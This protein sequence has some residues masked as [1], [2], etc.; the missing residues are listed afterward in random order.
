M[1]TLLD[2]V[3]DLAHSRICPNF[4]GFYTKKKKKYQNRRLLW[5]VLPL[6]CQHCSGLGTQCLL[7]SQ[8]CD[9]AEP[10]PVRKCIFLDAL[11]W[12]PLYTDLVRLNLCSTWP[13]PRIPW[14]KACVLSADRQ[15]EL[16]R[17][18]KILSTGP[19]EVTSKSSVAPG[20]I[21]QLNSYLPLP[22][23]SRMLTSY[24]C[25]EGYLWNYLLVSPRRTFCTFLL[26]YCIFVNH[27]P[28]TNLGRNIYQRNIL[29]APRKA[30]PVFSHRH[31][32]AGQGPGRELVCGCLLQE[33]I[34]DV[35]S[36]RRRISISDKRFSFSF[37]FIHLYSHIFNL[38]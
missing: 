6:P 8:Y 21:K 13:W 19:Q 32:V 38:K 26:E 37:S 11:V 17:A 29:S 33:W 1:K 12:I 27:G 34:P 36:F 5:N 28:K 25:Q 14:G 2:S 20:W 16:S 24:M 4:A 23:T 35:C 15:C 10:F 31:T 30:Q 7:N 22:Q 9:S 18:K 3:L